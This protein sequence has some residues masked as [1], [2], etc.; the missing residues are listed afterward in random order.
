VICERCSRWNLTPLEERWEAIEGC[1]K[2]YRDATKRVATDEIGLAK[3]NDGLAL[4]RIGR[5]VFPEYASWRY[6]ER[7]ARRRTRHYMMATAGVVGG[8]AV[9]IG[10]PMLAK[11]LL[12]VGGGS[13]YWIYNIYSGVLTSRR[14]KKT[15]GVITD[16]RLGRVEVKGK[17]AEMARFRSSGDSAFRIE[18]EPLPV[19]K[20]KALPFFLH[21]D[22]ARQF[23]RL[24]LPHINRKGSTDKQVAEAV[25]KLELANG[26]ADP[27]VT[28][29]RVIERA[30]Y[31]YSKLADVDPTLSVGLEMAVMEGQERL[32]L[33][34][35]L[36]LL[37]ANWKEAEELA[38][39]ADNLTLPEWVA[40][41]LGSLK[42]K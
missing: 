22:G 18:V 12:G 37:E 31:A 2:H 30:G 36:H 13:S 39:I 6:G 11:A 1:E 21:D 20:K 23:L 16:A 42:G 9:M 24:A 35:E 14:Q 26:P 25:Q 38:A 34:T 33:E 32:W 17:H 10:G 28:A 41:R 15:L 40:E 5:P 27:L 8:I 4:V 19:E 7:F 3:V 29:K